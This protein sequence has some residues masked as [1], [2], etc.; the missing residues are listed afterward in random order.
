M[1]IEPVEAILTPEQE[2]ALDFEE[3][4]ERGEARSGDAPIK[5][6]LDAH[7]DFWFEPMAL[8]YILNESGLRTIRDLIEQYA[9]ILPI[10]I[11]KYPHINQEDILERMRQ[12]MCEI[13]G[14]ICEYA[15]FHTGA[16]N[17]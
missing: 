9:D 5:Y 8:D 13:D 4:F 12:T 2:E 17:H 3:R 10:I 14:D 6:Y 15:V 11:E 16:N 1:D 7:P